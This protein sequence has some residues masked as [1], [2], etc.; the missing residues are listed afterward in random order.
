VA[1]AVDSATLVP[2]KVGGGNLRDLG[3]LA[4]NSRRTSSSVLLDRGV[5]AAHPRL[6]A[7]AA[8][9]QAKGLQVRSL[10][11]VGRGGGVTVVAAMCVCVDGQWVVG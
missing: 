10:A 3:S 1:A 7:M 8:A 9:L 2:S 4:A 5:Q 11:W 6:A